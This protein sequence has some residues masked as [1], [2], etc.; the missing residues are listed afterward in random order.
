MVLSAL[1]SILWL[2]DGAQAIRNVAATLRPG[3]GQVLFRDYAAGDLAEER[4]AGEGRSQR[5][6]D[7]FYARWDGTRAFYFTEVGGA[8]FFLECPL[9]PCAAAFIFGC[10]LSLPRLPPLCFALI[11]CWQ[12][13]AAPALACVRVLLLSPLFLLWCRVG[14]LGLFCS[15]RAPCKVLGKPCSPSVLLAVSTQSLRRLLV[16]LC[17]ERL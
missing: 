4:L 5:I 11:S 12:G 15:Q 14:I 8:P 16:P 6:A 17:K 13:G 1:S 2:P 9:T 7:G 10:S 3:T